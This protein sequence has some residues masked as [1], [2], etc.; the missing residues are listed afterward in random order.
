M[1]NEK[2]LRSMGLKTNSVKEF[3]IWCSRIKPVKKVG[4]GAV[5]E[6]DTLRIKITEAV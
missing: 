1:E 4:W 6:S 2:T 5:F 3:H